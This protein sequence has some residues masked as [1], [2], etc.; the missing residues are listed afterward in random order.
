MRKPKIQPF[1]ALEF[2]IRNIFLFCFLAHCVPDLVTLFISPNIIDFNEKEE[3]N[4]EQ[5]NN[6]EIEVAMVI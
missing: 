5:I 3:Y 6:E 4:P 2:R 1:T